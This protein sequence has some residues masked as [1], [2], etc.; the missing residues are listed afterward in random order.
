M[1]NHNDFNNEEHYEET[2]PRKRKFSWN[3]IALVLFI[4][5]VLLFAMGWGSGAR[6]GIIFFQSGAFQ[7]RSE[8]GGTQTHCLVD[9]IRGAENNHESFHSVDIGA[10]YMNIVILPATGNDYRLEVQGSFEPQI[11]LTNGVLTIRD[12]HRGQSAMSQWWVM[13][14][15]FTRHELRLYLPATA[16]YEITAAATSGNVHLEGLTSETLTARAASGNVRVVDFHA[17]NATLNST[18]GNVR[19]EN[20]FTREATL[21][22]T[23]GNVVVRGSTIGNLNANSTS[24]NVTVEATTLEGGTAI[25]R[26]VSGNVHFTRENT[27]Q[28]PNDVHYNVQTVTGTIRINNNRI[29]GRDALFFT[30]DPEPPFHITAGTTSGNVRLEF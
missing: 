2:Y 1:Q 15:N 18:S 11:T 9:M 30:A 4:L 6:G 22:A 25:L 13:D 5:G 3:K 26:S 12:A 8:S 29:Q 19:L 28:H 16:Y 27:P 20:S 23:S 14:L 21:R 7:V 10:T 24:G 17:P